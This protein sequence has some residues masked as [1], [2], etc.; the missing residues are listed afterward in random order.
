MSQKFDHYSI[1]INRIRAIIVYK[2]SHDRIDCKDV[3][4]NL[5]DIGYWR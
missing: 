2:A 3:S 1:V 5:K 4:L